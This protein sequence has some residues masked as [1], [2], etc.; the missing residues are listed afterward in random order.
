MKTKNPIK[1]KQGK[2]NRASG[3]E[4]ERRVRLDLEE[5]GWIVDKW[6]NN[7]EL[8]IYKHFLPRLIPAKRKW[9]GPNRPMVIG[10]GFP[11]FI[12]YHLD[13]LSK[14]KEIYRDSLFNKIEVIG[15]EVKTNGYLDKEEKEKCKW[16]LENN[17]F[18]KILIASKEKVKN[19]IKI[20]YKDFNSLKSNNLKKDI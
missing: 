17:I 12:A 13:W 6:S 2:K 15:V 10:T 5:K 18:S 16:L 14:D 4:F 3:A 1:V 19:R 7:V 9:A 20:I 8:D 11:D